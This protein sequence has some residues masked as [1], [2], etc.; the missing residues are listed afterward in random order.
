MECVIYQQM[1][2]TSMN[3]RVI[4][5]DGQLVAQVAHDGQWRR[6][7]TAQA[8]KIMRNALEHSLLQAGDEVVAWAGNRMVRGTFIGYVAGEIEVCVSRDDH[9]FTA[10]VLPLAVARRSGVWA[11]RRDMQVAAYVGECWTACRWVGYEDGRH[12]VRIGGSTVTCDRAHVAAD[13]IAM[14]LIEG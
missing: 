4:K 7:T 8:A 12:S 9:V 3:A 10:H 2:R 13:A 14:G 5:V 11:F 6:A 1:G